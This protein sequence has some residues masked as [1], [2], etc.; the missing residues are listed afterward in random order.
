MIQLL[1]SSLHKILEMAGRSVDAALRASRTGLL[2]EHS[3]ES[4]SEY[5]RIRIGHINC[6]G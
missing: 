4:Q 1:R 3:I 6:A 5:E 2:D